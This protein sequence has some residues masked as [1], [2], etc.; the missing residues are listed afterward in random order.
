[1]CDDMMEELSCET[2]LY[3]EWDV[4]AHQIVVCLQLDIINRN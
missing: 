1:M 4:C 3:R 2:N